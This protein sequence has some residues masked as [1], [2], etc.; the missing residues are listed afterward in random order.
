MKR[1]VKTLIALAVVVFVGGTVGCLIFRSAKARAQ[2]DQ[3]VNVE[4]S[5]LEANPKQYVGKTVRVKALVFGGPLDDPRLVDQKVEPT[6]VFIGY[7]FAPDAKEA[8]AKLQ[9]A[10]G[11]EVWIPHKAERC[12]RALAT[13]IGQFIEDPKRTKYNPRAGNQLGYQYW[14]IV[15]DL[16]DIKPC[17]KLWFHD[18]YK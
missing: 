18:V 14:I 8:S 15:T 6:G 11:P 2:Q 9:E 13:V 4:Y 17:P 5:V 3:P 16:Q 10:F 7:D 12:E 1:L